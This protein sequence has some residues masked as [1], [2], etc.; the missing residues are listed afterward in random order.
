[1][2]K[3]IALLLACALA[4]TGCKADNGGNTS[5][6]EDQNIAADADVEF[7]EIIPDFDSLSD[8]ALLRYVEDSVYYGNL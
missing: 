4:L 7:K 2:K 8:P 3:I 1:M 5:G 6:N